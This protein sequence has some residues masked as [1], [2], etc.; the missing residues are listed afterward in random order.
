M[1]RVQQAAQR[2]HQLGNVVKVQARGGFVKQEQHAFASRG[3]FAAGGR[4]RRIRQITRQFQ[5]LGFATAERGHGLAQAHVLQANVHNGLQGADD[6]AVVG[7][8]LRRL[9]DGEG[10]HIGHVQ[11]RIGI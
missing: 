1:P 3:L 7:K 5:A 8:Q 4:L 11:K 9:A 6:V 10:Q 2:P